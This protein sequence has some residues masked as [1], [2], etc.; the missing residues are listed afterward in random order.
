MIMT[1]QQK[2][3]E[4]EYEKQVIAQNSRS[5]DEY[6]QRVKALARRIGI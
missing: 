2:L 1:Y 5:A 3:V 4:Y 6:E